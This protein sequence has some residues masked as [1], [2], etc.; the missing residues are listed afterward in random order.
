MKKNT[1]NLLLAF[2]LLLIVAAVVADRLYLA[3]LEDRFMSFERQRIEI[4]NKLATA[5]I[6][7]EN[8]NHVRDLVFENMDF[9]GQVDTLGHETHIFNFITTCINDL[10]L[11]LVSV[12][13]VRPVTAGLVTTYGYEIELEGDFFKFGEL[14]SKFENS[15]RI[16]S[17]ESWDVALV[18]QEEKI[19]GGPE[20]K[21]IKVKM[22]INTY[23]IKKS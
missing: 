14:C 8:L 16:I 9:P 13:P 18:D 21:M 7:H 3:E 20:N 12:K 23:R 19:K 1:G 2:T 5:K 10:K 22:R 4:S 17:L 6:V 15:R 11:K